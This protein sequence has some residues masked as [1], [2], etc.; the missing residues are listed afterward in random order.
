[1]QYEIK[2]LVNRFQSRSSEMDDKI[3]YY[4]GCVSEEI[5]KLLDDMNKKYGV[6]SSDG[7]KADGNP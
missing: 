4:Q 3:T 2:T 7:E 6:P 5:H 1:M